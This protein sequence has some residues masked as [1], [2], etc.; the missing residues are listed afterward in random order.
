LDDSG[1]KFMVALDS[2]YPRIKK[3]QSAIS[4]KKVIVVGFGGD[5]QELA[6]GDYHFE[7]ALYP[8]P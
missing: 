8:R 6:E 4:L 2:F 7:Q 3:V 5:K 1:A